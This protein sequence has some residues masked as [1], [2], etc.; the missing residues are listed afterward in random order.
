MTDIEKAKEVFCSSK[1]TCVLC[2][3]DKVL[4]SE[5]KGIAP[6]MELISSGTDIRGFSAADRIVGKAAALLF[7]LAGIAGVY[8]GVLSD[9]AA[10]VL[11]AHGIPYSCGAHAG[12]IVNRKG[13]GVCP[14]EAAVKDIDDPAEAYTV[15]LAKIVELKRSAG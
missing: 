12:Y 1:Y 5:R 15:L 7:V 2:R 6:I 14:M 3:G 9:G 4:T 8:A 13:D 11:E 10:A